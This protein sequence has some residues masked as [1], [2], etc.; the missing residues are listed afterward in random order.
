MSWVKAVKRVYTQWR[1]S[2][3]E[4]AASTTTDRKSFWYFN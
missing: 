1:L 2:E 3:F 4:I